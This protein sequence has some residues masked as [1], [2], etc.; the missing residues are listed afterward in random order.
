MS[1]LPPSTYAEVTVNVPFLTSA[2]TYTIPDVL[3]ERVTVGHLVTVPFDGR[4]VQGVVTGLTYSAPAVRLHP[5]ENLLDPS[6]CSPRPRSTWPPGWRR[7]TSRRS[8]TASPH[9]AARRSA[10]RADQR[11]SLN[12]DFLKLATPGQQSVIDLVQAKGPLRGRQIDR[13]LSGHSNWR[14]EVQP[15]VRRGVLSRQSV[16]EPPTVRAKHVR[17]ARLAVSLAQMEAARPTFSKVASKAN[18]LG[19]ILDFLA[20]D[21]DRRRQSGLRRNRRSLPDLKELA[22]RGL[23]DLGKAEIWRDTLAGQE[24]VPL[25]PPTS[26]PTRSPSGTK[27]IPSSTTPQLPI[28]NYQ[29][30]LSCFTASPAPAKPKSALPL[31]RRHPRP[32]PAPVSSSSPRSP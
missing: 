11:Y 3:H 30:L 27:S 17:T 5:L 1:S 7:P 22:E 4:R 24:F 29:L 21:F 20:N 2:F 14:A 19:A 18:R 26:P 8:S 15:L 6:P 23:I 32:R 25:Q 31:P 13:A 28:T 9:A 10:K 12:I 16:L